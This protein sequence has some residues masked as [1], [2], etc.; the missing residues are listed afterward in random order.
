MLSYMVYVC[1]GPCHAVKLWRFA[2]K[3]TIERHFQ[4]TTFFCLEGFCCFRRC[5]DRFLTLTV[6]G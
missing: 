2:G 5:A 1:K 3:A 4:T 6:G